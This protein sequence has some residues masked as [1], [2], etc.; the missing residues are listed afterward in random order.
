MQ[1]FEG[2]SRLEV[3]ALPSTTGVSMS[4]CDGAC[5]SR[6]FTLMRRSA[7]PH[8]V[9]TIASPASAAWQAP[10]RATAGRFA[11]GRCV[12]SLADAQCSRHLVI[13]VS[14]NWL[15]S[16]NLAMKAVRLHDDVQGRFWG[17]G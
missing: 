3:G 15:R 16:S 10:L 17:T 6:M 12:R 2:E 11:S 8:P 5:F 14:T 9:S 4:L 1:L 7:L 13:A